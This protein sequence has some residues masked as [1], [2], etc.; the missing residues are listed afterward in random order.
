MIASVR[1]TVLAITGDEVVIEVG[2]VGLEITCTPTT[3]APLRVGDQ[4]GLATTLI[5]REDSLT[6][7][8]FAD[9]DERA[10]FTLLQ[11]VNGVGPRVAQAVLATLRP[12]ELRAAVHA[13]DLVT[14]TRVPGV[15]R[16]G[17]ER[18]VLDLRDKIGAPTGSATTRP[19][20]ID[21]VPDEESWRAGVRVGLT[22]LGW[23]AKEADTALDAVQ[24]EFGDTAD[25]ADVG[26]LLRAALRH[27][28]RR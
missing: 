19:S 3:L 7:F 1:G 6:L 9:A 18:M 20:A 2:G 28:D 17:A 10:C 8:G 16:K 14:L 22:S 15:G 13:N 21:P 27:L 24:R 25:G 26:V 11:K 12:D 4:A 5:V 23:S